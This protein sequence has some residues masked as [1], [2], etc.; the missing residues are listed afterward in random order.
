MKLLPSERLSEAEVQ[1]GLQFSIRDGMA[2]E[3]MIVLTG[4]AFLTSLALKMGASNFQIGVLAALPTFTNIFQLLSLWLLQRYRNRRVIAVA[5]SFLARFPLLM[6]GTLPLLFSGGASLYALISFLCFHYF[7]GSLVGTSWNSWMKD[8]VPERML[9]SFFSRRTRLCQT[10]N[11]TLS[12]TSALVVDYIKS[13]HPQQEIIA[14]TTMFMLAGVAGMVGVWMLSRVPEPR[15]Q[16]VNK[17]VFSQLRQPLRDRNFRNMLL[18]NASWIFALNLATPFFNVYMIKALQLPLSGIIALGLLSQVSS[19]FSVRMWG[20]YIDRY[21]NKNVLYICAPIY[22]FCLLAWALTALVSSLAGITALLIFINIGSGISTA[23]INLSLNNIGIKLAAKE[24][25]MVYLTAKSMIIAAASA[26]APLLGGLLADSF[27]A[28]QHTLTGPLPH[29]HT[30]T[31]N[32]FFLISAVF[33][34]LAIKLLRRVKENGEVD[35]TVINLRMM[36]DF[37]YHLREAPSR[38]MLRR[39]IYLPEKRKSAGHRKKSA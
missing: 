21:S 22:T 19:I 26:T 1:E 25:G 38:Q 10:L 13:H 17:N 33:A 16:V 6:I 34:M 15:M 24:Q 8:L 14:Y 20:R 18:F 30:Y 3:T 27:S 35:K 23:G 11:V 28:W 2:A 39:I 12:L 5:G 37:R 29:L 36:A 9:G 31:W 7:F 32:I 4:G